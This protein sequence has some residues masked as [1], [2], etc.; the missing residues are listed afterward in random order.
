MRAGRIRYDR[1][2]DY[3]WATIDPVLER[4]ERGGRTTIVRADTLEF[5]NPKRQAVAVGNVRV[6]REKL[7]ATGRRAE[8]YRSE[9]RALLLGNPRAWDEQGVARGDSIEIRFANNRVQALR[10][11]PNAVVEYEARA[12]SARGER[13]VAQGDTIT[14]HFA[15][16][17]ARE[18]VIVGHAE[19]RY[20]PSAA[21]SVEG[22]GNVQ[23][24]RPGGAPPRRGRT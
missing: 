6:E 3:A 21:D 18:A 24:G 10:M 1:R 12:D 7:R 4:Q 5:D 2:V 16:E 22:G 20:W 15:E 8:F 19:S 23:I 17:E 14:V 13:N 9:D 11:W